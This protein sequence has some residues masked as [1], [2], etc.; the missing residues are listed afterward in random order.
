MK[1]G[2]DAPTGL[3]SFLHVFT[4]DMPLL[5]EL[6]RGSARFLSLSCLLVPSLINAQSLRLGTNEISPG[7]TLQ[8]FVPLTSRAKWEISRLHLA[9]DFAKGALVLPEGFSL[10]KPCRLLVISV[11]SGGSAIAAMA[12]YT[13]V[14]LN[15]GWALLAADGPRVAAEDDSIQWNWAMLSSTLDYLTRAWPQA[16]QWTMVCAGFSGG[17]KRSGSVAAALMK[18]NFRVIGIFMGG[19]NEDRV[20]LGIK[21]YA[22]SDLFKSVPIFLSCGLQDPIAGP[23]PTAGVKQSLEQSGFRLIRMESYPGGHRL[24]PDQLKLALKWF[25]QPRR[26]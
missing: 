18:E 5:T 20:S 11:P 16:R 22:P 9:A 24:D 4:I 19:C 25:L 6:L 23:T 12:S 21:L 13:N 8:F 2:H 7:K 26:A 17:A 1:T 10:K 15:E 3:F 14:A